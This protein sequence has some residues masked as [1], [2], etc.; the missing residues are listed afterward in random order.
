MFQSKTMTA[1][2]ELIGRVAGRA[3]PA[4]VL[5]FGLAAASEGHATTQYFLQKTNMNTART[6]YISG[7]AVNENAYMAPVAFTAFRGTG[8]TP[9]TGALSAPFNLIGFC[10]D[11]FHDISLGTVNLKYNDAYD[12]TTNS[13]YI[14]NTPWAGATPLSTA[15]V[16]QVGRLVNY[17][18]K[19]Y[20][21][22]GPV[23]ND[24]L[25]RMSAVQGAIWQVINPNYMVRSSN[26]NLTI[27]NAVNSYINTY[28][29]ANY[30]ASLTGYGAVKSG[31]TFLSE[32]NKYGKRT[33]HQSFAFATVP[34]PATWAV[35]I[36]G[37]GLTGAMLRR[38][39]HRLTLA[40]ATAQRN[41]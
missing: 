2:G 27:R 19:I 9:Q 13:K 36:I 23:T 38:S 30:Y 12:L 1:Q 16:I 8:A 6:G 22:V 4:L 26:S 15:Q 29:G 25:N 31:I 10:V 3:I 32:T 28:S 41:T 33:A 14:T 21:S 5:A 39:R 17:G 20:K 34:E 18:S 24:K 40:P 37:F 7:P 35:M 11:I